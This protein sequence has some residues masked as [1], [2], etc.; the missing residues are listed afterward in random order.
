MKTATGKPVHP[1]VAIAVASLVNALEWFDLIIF[2]FLSV[3]I[4][5][6]PHLRLGWYSPSSRVCWFSPNACWI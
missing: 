4:A 1:A 2:G 5:K 6:H 3:V